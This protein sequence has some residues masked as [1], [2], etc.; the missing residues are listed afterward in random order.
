MRTEVGGDCE[1]TLKKINLN[2][3]LKAYNRLFNSK[4]NDVDYTNTVNFNIIPPPNN[5]GSHSQSTAS[6]LLPMITANIQFPTS[7]NLTAS[8]LPSISCAAWS[9]LPPI[10]AAM[11]VPHLATTGPYVETVAELM[12]VAFKIAAVSSGGEDLGNDT[13][14]DSI[15]E[16]CKS[17]ADFEDISYEALATAWR[18]IETTPCD[19]TLF[20]GAAGDVDGVVSKLLIAEITTDDQARVQRRFVGVPL[21]IASE[22]RPVVYFPQCREN[23]TLVFSVE[24]LGIMSGKG[25]RG[26]MTVL[27]SEFLAGGEIAGGLMSLK[28]LVGGEEDGWAQVSVKVKEREF[29]GVYNLNVTVGESKFKG[30]LLMSWFTYLNRCLIVALGEFS[31]AQSR[32]L[33]YSDHIVRTDSSGSAI[34]SVPPIQRFCVNILCWFAANETIEH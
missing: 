20:G 11:Q 32:I 5:A 15:A 29:F 34:Q 25:L 23:D 16:L 2:L 18:N 4:S 8:T 19:G 21:K 26:N 14:L 17:C 27:P 10:K 3:F 31:D 9:Q 28:A 22:T 30:M 13:L 12:K 7:L 24:G 6:I 33:L 1:N